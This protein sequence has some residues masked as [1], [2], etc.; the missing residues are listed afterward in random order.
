MKGDC[1]RMFQAT[2]IAT[3][4]AGE[5]AFGGNLVGDYFSRCIKRRLAPASLNARPQEIRT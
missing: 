4:P 5:K 3:V 1:L 2:V